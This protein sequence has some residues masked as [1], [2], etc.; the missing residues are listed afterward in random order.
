MRI[1]SILISYILMF[2]GLI[3][4]INPLLIMNREVWGWIPGQYLVVAGV[5]IIIIG[6]IVQYIWKN[7]S[8]SKD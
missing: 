7:E 3:I 1:I 5:M 4:I 8:K 2:I 6:V